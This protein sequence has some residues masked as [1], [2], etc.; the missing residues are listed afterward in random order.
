MHI[1]YRYILHFAELQGGVSG[2]RSIDPNLQRRTIRR[3]REAATA[4]SCVS[5]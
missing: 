5:H 1:N 3:E 2:W 4:G